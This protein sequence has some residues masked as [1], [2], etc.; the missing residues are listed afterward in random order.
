M[1][2]LRL[3]PDDDDPIQ[4]GYQFKLRASISS[5]FLLCLLL[6]LI[7]SLYRIVRLTFKFLSY[8]PA[9]LMATFQSLLS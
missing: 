9:A 5:S 3:A 2:T 6:L 1:A 7:V 4:S 8:T